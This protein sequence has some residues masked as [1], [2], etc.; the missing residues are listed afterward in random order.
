MAD[1]QGPPTPILGVAVGSSRS[2]S[3]NVYHW[4]AGMHRVRVLGLGLAVM[5]CLLATGLLSVAWASTAGPYVG[6]SIYGYGGDDLGDG[7]PGLHLTPELINLAPGVSPSA[8]SQGGTNGEAI[9]SDGRLYTWGVYSGDGTSGEELTPHELELPGGALP[10]VI[11]PGAGEFDSAIGSDHKLYSWGNA[12]Y[13]NIGDG[14]VNGQQLTPK[15]IQLAAGVSPVAVSNGCEAGLAIGSNGKLYGWGSNGAFGGG[16]F[17]Y[18]PTVIEVNHGTEEFPDLEAFYPKA[19]ASG[20]NM[21]VAIGPEGGLYTWGIDHRGTLGMGFESNSD[22][23]VSHPKEISLGSGVTATAVSSGVNLSAAIG[24]N[25]KVYAWGV[26]Q[27]VPTV[28]SL[29]AGVTPTAIAA[30]A[31][32]ALALGSDD[33]IYKWEEPPYKATAITPPPGFTPSAL[34]ASFAN[35][36]LLGAENIP[37]G[38]KLTL[39]LASLYGH[40]TDL[41][42]GSG[43][44]VHGDTSV[45]L[46]QCVTTY[47]TTSSCDQTNHVTAKVGTTGTEIGK[48]TKVPVK[49]D[50]EQIGNHNDSCGLLGSPAC[51]IVAVG[52]TGDSTP[53]APLGFALPSASVYK[54]IEVANGYKDAVKTKHFPIGDHILAQQCDSS[55]NP[56]TNLATNCDH[57]SKIEG[58]VTA[59]G[60]VKFTK[61]GVVIKDGPN[62][63]ETGTGTCPAGGTCSVVVSDA[64]S[65]GAYAVVPINLAP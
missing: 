52:N 11:S 61:A 16:P 30:G 32:F 14:T 37:A 58:T 43:W 45:T 19:I 12:N 20:C 13:G 15:E 4:G 36:Y 50:V 22:A 21:A 44:Q 7:T 41:V 60:A 5:T 62:Y 23:S 26:Y 34:V 40:Y 6:W 2:S 10:T 28:V 25:D 29:P 56:E 51:Y 42:S 54:S 8:I 55:V 65:P 24:S 39:K 33:N 63:T 9:G 64:N 1:G 17:H 47:Y 18:T 38:G 57:E 35:A 59:S 3:V 48:V 46:Y 49:L 31:T 27:D 53:S